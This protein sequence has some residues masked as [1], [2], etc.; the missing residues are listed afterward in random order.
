VLELSTNVFHNLGIKRWIEDERVFTTPE[1]YFQICKA[2]FPYLSIQL[3]RIEH[4]PNSSHPEKIQQLID[5]ISKVVE[6]DLSHIEG[7]EIAAG[8]SVHIIHLLELLE[9]LSVHMI[10]NE[11]ASVRSA[12]E[13]DNKSCESRPHRDSFY[14]VIGINQEFVQ[15][16]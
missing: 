7:R 16:G 2:I 1:I 3:Y 8:K 13:N 4:L 15:K 6:T 12:E 14:T 10:L 11:S 9:A 5:M